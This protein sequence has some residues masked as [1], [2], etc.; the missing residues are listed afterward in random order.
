MTATSPETELCS[1]LYTELLEESNPIKL[2]EQLDLITKNERRAHQ[3]AS[4]AGTPIATITPYKFPESMRLQK[5]KNEAGDEF[6]MYEKVVKDTKGNNVIQSRELAIDPLTGAFDANYPSG[7]LLLDDLI[8]ENQGK[9]TF[10][11]IDV[12][13]LGYVNNNFLKG[14]NAGDAY[15]ETIAKSVTDATEGKAQLFKLGGDEYG[16]VIHESDPKKAQEI[17]QKIIDQCYS[18]EVHAGF[19]ENTIARA[20]E[21]RA[22]RKVGADG[23]KIPLEEKQISEIK[24]YAPYSR[25]GI[26]I[27]SALVENGVTTEAILKAAEEQAVKQ[28]IVTKEALNISAKKYG[29]AEA[30]PGAKPD[31]KYKPTADSPAVIPASSKPPK[32]SLQKAKISL[33]KTYGEEKLLGEKFRFGEVAAIEQKMPDGSSILKYNR[34]FTAKN[35]ERHFVSREL[36]VNAKVG[37]IDGTHESGKYVLEQLTEGKNA[38]LHERGVIWINALNLGKINY[39]KDGTATGDRLLAATAAVI[40]KELESSGIPIKMAGS[41]FVIVKDGE[42]KEK[43][44]QLMTKINNALV[45]NTEIKKIYSEQIDYVSSQIKRMKELP[46]S[47]ENDKKLGELEESF[48]VV[49]KLKPE[50]S[51]EGV[52]PTVLDNLESIMK[53]TRGLHY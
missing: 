31:L 14:R 28:K 16:V 4:N 9:A 21:V 49:S 41:E 39:F 5:F 30:I 48:K 6:I 24:E 11:F 7:K 53:Q 20:E 51:I 2:N 37:F 45:N 52:V 3:L 23:K 36:V 22:A 27:G 29:G 10:A 32:T 8:K 46:K 42:S 50:Y 12:N 40:K 34:Y 25:E 38:V 15:L 47:S 18:K 35:G 43:L 19:K 33:T 1:K 17:L 44:T 13:N 26:S